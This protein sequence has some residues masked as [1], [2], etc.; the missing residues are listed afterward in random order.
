MNTSTARRIASLGLVSAAATFALAAP[1]TAGPIP[2]DPVPLHYGQ[3]V[4]A[5]PA[6]TGTGSS[7]TTVSASGTE[8]AQVGYGAAGGVAL[9]AAGA[10]GFVML[11]RH[12]HLPHHA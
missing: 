3:G 12:Q 6:S 9:F 8:W 4:D 10:A 1:A 7:T 5:A 11:R 2:P